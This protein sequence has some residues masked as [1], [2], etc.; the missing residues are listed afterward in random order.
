MGAKGR[1]TTDR[2]SFARTISTGCTCL[3]CEKEIG[4]GQP[5]LERDYTKRGK[6]KGKT[7]LHD[8][9]DCFQT[10]EL[11]VL[12]RLAEKRQTQQWK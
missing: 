9:D 6:V 3:G 5:M 1:F 4:A 12:E 10:W 8:H 7:R 11:R 2:S